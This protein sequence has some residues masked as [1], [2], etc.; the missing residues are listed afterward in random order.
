MKA[1][2]LA[3]VLNVVSIL[4]VTGCAQLPAEQL[5]A[6]AKAVEAAKTAGAEDYAKEDYI[7]LEEQFSLAKD[8]L[9]KQENVYSVFRSYTDA[10]DLL[11]QVVLSGQQVAVVAVQKKEAAKLAAMSTE[12]EALQ[13]MASVKKLMSTAPNGKERAAVATIKEDVAGLETSLNAVHQLID[14]GDYLAADTQSKAIKAKSAAISEELLDAI[15][16]TKG[17]KNKTHA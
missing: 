6:A 16:K 14:K 13:M 10:D 2:T 15:A 3:A 4:V 1:I 9:A 8:A 5:E 11:K 17:R 12:K 7:K